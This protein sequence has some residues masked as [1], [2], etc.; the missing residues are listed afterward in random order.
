MA[1]EYFCAYH[2]LLYSLEPF[3]DAERGRLF[4]AAL[5]YSREGAEPQL[6]GNERYIWPTIR[7][8]IDRDR[9]AYDAKC[10]K[11]RAN[12]TERMRTLPNANERVR[13]YTN[14]CESSQEKEKEKEKGEE[15]RKEK[16]NITR[17]GAAAPRT[18]K[19]QHGKFGWVK[20]TE[21]EYN[22]LVADLGAEEVARCIEYVDE[23]AQSTGNK[24][25][26]KDWN[27]VIRKCSRDGWGQRGKQPEKKEF[28]HDPSSIDKFMKDFGFKE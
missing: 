23:S 1:R 20:L 16:D 24:N 9:A 6:S 19:K 26:W 8:M 18:P 22:K 14:A 27:L 4:T 10:D 7:A 13:T 12:A 3:G 21:D 28:R 17:V 2:S 15:E 11:N 5:V 25:K